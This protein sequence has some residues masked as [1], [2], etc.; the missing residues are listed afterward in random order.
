M[1]P[2][3]LTNR[4]FMQVCWVVPD[5]HAAIDAWVGSAGVGPFFW[6]DGVAFADGHHRGEPAA[7]PAVRAAIAYAGDLQVEL[8][9]QDNDDPGVFRDVFRRGEG[10]VHHLAI[11][12]T[13]YE[14]ER[15]AYLAAGAVLAFEGVTGTSRTCW[16]DTSP[17]L[18]FMIELLEPS[19]T[20]EAWF[21]TMRAAART[22]DGSDAIVVPGAGTTEIARH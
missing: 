15:D 20:R 6:F 19:E 5:L 14:A 21:S 13:D 10:G 16:I 22:W 3:L 2:A 9:C 8:V 11:T 4:S 1:I 18:G 7:F 17:T 12:C